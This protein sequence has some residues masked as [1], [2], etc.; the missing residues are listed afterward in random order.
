MNLSIVKILAPVAIALALTSG[1][2]AGS[3]KSNVQVRVTQEFVEQELKWR[4]RPQPGFTVRWT[5]EVIGGEIAICG[6]VA[7]GDIQLRSESRTLL[8][9]S[10][11]TYDDKKVMKNLNFF[12]KAKSARKLIGSTANCAS[13]GVKAPRGEYTVWMNL[14]SGSFPG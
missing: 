6:A 8:S 13:T 11:V 9:R 3:G 10:Y 2:H 4:G 1:A 7:F 14:G 12:A 5:T